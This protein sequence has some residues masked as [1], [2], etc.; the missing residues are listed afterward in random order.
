MFISGVMRKVFRRDNHVKV[1]QTSKL[2]FFY[3]YLLLPN[4]CLLVLLMTHKAIK[5]FA[6]KN[7]SVR[8][9]INNKPWCSG[10]S[11]ELHF[12][13]KLISHAGTNLS[14]WM[15]EEIPDSL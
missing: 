14:F 3:F 5:K 9:L 15:L 11:V 2:F 6:K 7:V 13:D 1:D 10:Y 8:F 4:H 12:P